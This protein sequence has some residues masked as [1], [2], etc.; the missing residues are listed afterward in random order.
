MV[1]LNFKKIRSNLSKPTVALLEETSHRAWCSL[2]S[3]RGAPLEFLVCR[4]GWRVPEALCLHPSKVQ[5][6]PPDHSRLRNCAPRPPDRLRLSS[7]RILPDPKWP[8]CLDQPKLEQ[9]R[10][11]GNCQQHTASVQSALQKSKPFAIVFS[12]RCTLIANRL[13]FQQSS[14]L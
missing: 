13:V 12:F 3:E 2:S 8:G 6:G 11:A 10:K 5:A 7:P 9:R 4:L 14:L 1:N